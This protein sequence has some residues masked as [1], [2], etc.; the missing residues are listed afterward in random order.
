MCTYI[1]S[2]TN[3]SLSNIVHFIRIEQ[4][5]KSIYL[6]LMNIKVICKT[7]MLYMLLAAPPPSCKGFAYIQF[8][9]LPS[10]SSTDPIVETILI[11]ST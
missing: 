11:A 8:S 10:S 5:L 7:Y 1:M 9:N 6:C 4:Q 2:Q 3:A